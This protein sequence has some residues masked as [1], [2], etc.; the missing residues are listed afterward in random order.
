LPAKK[1][2]AK[3]KSLAYFC[4]IEPPSTDALN[5]SHAR[6]EKVATSKTRI[7]KGTD[8]LNASPHQNRKKENQS[9]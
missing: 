2:I 7:E 9:Q 1:Q 3:Q 6:T 4:S 5:A 8:A